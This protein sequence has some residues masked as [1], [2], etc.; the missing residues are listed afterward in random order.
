M[1][2]SEALTRQY[3]R[4]HRHWLLTFLR[5]KCGC[6]EL[7]ADLV[8]DTFVRIMARD[9]E[10]SAIREPRAYLRTIAHGLLANQWRRQDVERA[11]LDA[12]ANQPGASMPSPEERHM[13]LETLEQIIGLLEEL[14]P[15]V[16]QAFLLSQLDGLT[17]PQIAQQLGL[18]VNQVQK[19]MLK[20]VAHCYKALYA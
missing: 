6:S 2:Q 17:Y 9:Q 20:A 7:A 16:R 12:L 15:Q 18:T 5:G 1:S 14:K 8:Q 11:Y 3:Y 19:A 10:L 4:E 13:V